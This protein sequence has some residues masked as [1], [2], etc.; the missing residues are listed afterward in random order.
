MPAGVSMGTVMNLIGGV[1]QIGNTAMTFVK[2]QVVTVQ[3]TVT[4]VSGF[5][6]ISPPL[7]QTLSVL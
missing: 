6:Q 4:G 1:P 3:N 7:L 5:V 2:E